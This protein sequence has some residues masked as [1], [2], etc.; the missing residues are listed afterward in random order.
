M[1]AIQKQNSAVGLTYLKNVPQPKIV[2][3]DEVLIRVKAA[4]ICG[5]D[6]DIYRADPQ[7]MTRMQP[8]LPVITGHE[9]MLPRLVLQ[10]SPEGI[11][12]LLRSDGAEKDIGV[13]ERIGVLVAG[14]RLEEARLEAEAGA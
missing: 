14:V 13:V 11:V 2:Q 1:Q 12:G 5:T 8:C 9:F 3:S 6:V 4:A 7:L 10:S